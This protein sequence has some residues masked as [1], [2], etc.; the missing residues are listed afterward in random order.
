MYS[1]SNH[2]HLPDPHQHPHHPQSYM[3]QVMAANSGF[4]HD[5]ELQNIGENKG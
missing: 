5:R 3:N 1:H 4:F 2:G